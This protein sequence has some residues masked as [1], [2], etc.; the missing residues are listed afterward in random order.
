MWLLKKPAL[1]RVLPR[2]DGALWQTSAAAAPTLPVACPCGGPSNARSAG[3]LERELPGVTAWFACFLILAHLAGH[4]PTL[5]GTLPTLPGTLPVAVVS[6]RRPSSGI[7]CP[8]PP[9]RSRIDR[10]TPPELFV[11][12]EQHDA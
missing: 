8:R 6:L 3:P 5:P 11:A 4:L 10:N 7:P 12:G 2:R 1:I 9:G